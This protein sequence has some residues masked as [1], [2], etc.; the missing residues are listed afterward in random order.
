MK[1]DIWSS[2]TSMNHLIL[3]QK[4]DCSDNDSLK[5]ADAMTMWVCVDAV[6][7]DLYLQTTFMALSLLIMH[8]GSDECIGEGG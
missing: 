4:D 1:S 2:N 6:A 5:H 3:S 8:A 7:Y